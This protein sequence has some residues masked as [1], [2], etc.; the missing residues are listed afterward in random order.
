MVILN[1]YS[2]YV[3]KLTNPNNLLALILKIKNKIKKKNMILDYK[4]I[5]KADCSQ[6]KC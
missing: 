2:N 4:P 3:I 1:A 5:I 6:N